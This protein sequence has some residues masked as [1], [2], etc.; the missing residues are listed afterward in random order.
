MYCCFHITFNLVAPKLTP[1]YVGFKTYTILSNSMA[2]TI[3]KGDLVIVGYKDFNELEVN[4]IVAATPREQIEIL[5]YI[6]E[7]DKDQKTFRTKS[8]NAKKND[9]WLLKENDYIGIY[10][11]KISYLGHIFLYLATWYG[12]LSVACSLI[13]FWLLLKQLNKQKGCDDCEEN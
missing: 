8:E 6:S 9:F 3:N 10:K 1:K 5:H 7:I 13:L 12:K 2:P 11:F 4:D